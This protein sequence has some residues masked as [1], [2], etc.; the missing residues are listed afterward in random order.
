[1]R[2][3]QE[4]T[5]LPRV[6]LWGEP[7]VGKSSLLNALAGSAA[8]IVS[9]QSGTTRDFVT[10]LLPLNGIQ[11]LL[12]DTAGQTAAFD[13][14]VSAAAQQTMKRAL[15]AADLTLLCLDASRPPS[16][17]ETAQLREPASG[18]RIVVLTKCDVRAARAP[19][20]GEL[21][22]SSASGAGL[23]QL[24]AAIARQLHDSRVESA[25]VGTAVRC[26]ESLQQAAHALANARTLAAASSGE[27]VVAAEVRLALD[28]LG[29]VVGA[30]YTDDVLDRIFSRFCIGK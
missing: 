30:V 6:V 14:P 9:P 2:S 25:L 20:P 29:E 10:Q 3:R 18:P 24:R 13:D 12:V 17:W 22:T 8:A 11:C 4:A 16:A 1:M 23:D 5:E 7:N 19:R 21:G 28:G 26:R 27:E 15:A